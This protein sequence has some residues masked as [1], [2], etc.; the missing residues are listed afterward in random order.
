MFSFVFALVCQVLSLV[1]LDW[2]CFCY[3][4]KLISA[5]EVLLLFDCSFW[6][7]DFVWVQCF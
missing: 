2:F 1:L 4:F 5:L 6:I 7:V 3:S